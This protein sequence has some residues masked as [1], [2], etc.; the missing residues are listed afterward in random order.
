M[1]VSTLV[2]ECYRAD[3]D[4]DDGAL[5]NTMVAVRDRL[6]FSTSIYNPVDGHKNS[7]QSRKS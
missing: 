3:S 5:Y 7:Q 4:R 1:L 2:A 6:N